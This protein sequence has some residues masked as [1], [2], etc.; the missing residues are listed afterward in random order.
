[1]KRATHRLKQIGIG[2]A[3]Y[4][5]FMSPLLIIVALMC[6]AISMNMADR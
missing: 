6:L 4:L 2:I 5:L 3:T 1:M